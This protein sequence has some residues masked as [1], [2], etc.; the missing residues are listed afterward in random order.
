VHTTRSRTSRGLLLQSRTRS[1]PAT[2]LASSRDCRFR[3]SSRHGERCEPGQV[4]ACGQQ[5]HKTGPSRTRASPN[6]GLL[7]ANRLRLASRQ[8][9]PREQLWSTLTG[10]GGT[11]RS[12]FAR[13]VI[14][15]EL[16][17]DGIPAESETTC[18]WAGAHVLTVHTAIP[19]ADLA[20]ELHSTF[21]GHSG[22][23]TH[24][25]HLT[26]GPP[27][28]EATIT[29][30]DHHEEHLDPTSAPCACAYEHAQ[31]LIE[32]LGRLGYRASVNVP[33]ERAF[34]GLVR[35]VPGS[36]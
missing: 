14:D 8:Q 34:D 3:Q 9:G 25:V 10:V 11:V 21:V 6:A 35:I 22:V 31:H 36:T 2:A 16:V 7:S 4:A 26:L 15:L 5:G 29:A 19:R 18:T 28:H 23:Q 27:G 17:V 20:L 13:P 12:M 32:I 24:V 30:A 1:T 33:G